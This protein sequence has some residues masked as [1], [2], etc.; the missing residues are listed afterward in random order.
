MRFV[1]DADMHIHSKVSLCSNDD[2][3]TNERI[4]R[5]AV[6]NG[7]KTVVL[8][9]HFWDRSVPCESDWYAK[10]D[11]EHLKKAK[12]LPQAPSFL[13]GMLTSALVRR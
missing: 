6:D 10:Q 2:E 12:P 4:L 5:Y 11:L 1:V 3:Q 9:D 13:A 7:L 8:T